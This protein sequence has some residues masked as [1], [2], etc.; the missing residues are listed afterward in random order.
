MDIEKMIEKTIFGDWVRCQYCIYREDCEDREA[1]DG[2]YNG[3]P[4]S[5]EYLNGRKEN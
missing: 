2:C 1:R 5:D 3:E 4:E